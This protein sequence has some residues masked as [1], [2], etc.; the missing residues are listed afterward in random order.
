M[1]KLSVC[2]TMLL[3]FFTSCYYDSKN[4]KLDGYW[5]MELVHYHQTDGTDSIASVS[6]RNIFWAFQQKLLSIRDTDSLSFIYGQNI[7]SE[8]VTRFRY[9]GD[10]LYISPVYLHLRTSDILIGDTSTTTLQHIGI[11]GNKAV[12]FIEQLSDDKM[13]LQSKYSRIHFT[14]F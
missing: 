10:S 1:T 8:V 9:I 2:V 5:R 11:E 13:I 12:F 14:K 3:A 4:G 6:E 7:S